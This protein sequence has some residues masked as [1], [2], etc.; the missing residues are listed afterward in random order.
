[1][2]KEFQRMATFKDFVGELTAVYKR[3]VKPTVKITYSRDAAD[4]ARPYFEEI[5]DDHEEFK[6]MHLNNNNNVVNMHH[7]SSGSDTGTI[8][9]IRDIMQKALLIKCH[10]LILCHCHPSG[11]TKP[12]KQDI[13]VTEKIKKAAELFEIKLLDHIILTRETY[14]SFADQGLL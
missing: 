9:P 7:V 5:M 10:S 14:T 13:K 6:V 11:S 2:S 4:F 3:T 12:S 1:M 8:V